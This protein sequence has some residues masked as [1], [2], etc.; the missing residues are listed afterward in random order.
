[1]HACRVDCDMLPLDCSHI[2]E[3][4]HLYAW[5]S[6][7]QLSVHD[8]SVYA[9]VFQERRSDPSSSPLGETS[10]SPLRRKRKQT[11]LLPGCARKSR[12]LSRASRTCS[13]RD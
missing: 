12:S 9:P 11:L 1:M 6:G 4:V 10:T 5:L 7:G 3:D 13:K 8:W 2:A